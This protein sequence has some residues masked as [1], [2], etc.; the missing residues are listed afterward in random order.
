MRRIVAVLAAASALWGA[1]PGVAVAG[2][3]EPVESTVLNVF[4]NDRQQV[5]PQTY[6]L[7]T[8]YVG[9]YTTEGTHWSD[10]Y[11][12]V[13]VCRQGGGGVRCRQVHYAYGDSDLTNPGD[14]YDFDA[15]GLSGAHL[16]AGY[17]LQSY[18]G[19][20]DPVGD[21]RAVRIV[22]DAAGIGEISESRWVNGWQSGCH[23]Y[24]EIG[25]G[26]S[27]GAR[28]IGA[29]DGHDLGPTEEAYLGSDVYR[30]VDHQC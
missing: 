22:T 8:W 15:D 5:D 11:L 2:G 19:Y 1:A 17:L 25:R 23:W 9:V 18:D 21:P 16:E 29:I 13:Q 10:L 26:E 3:R 12:D 24:L 6:R 4:W 27:R 14:A 7:R 20:G 30:H 28:A